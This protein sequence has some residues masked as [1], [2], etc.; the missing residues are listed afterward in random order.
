MKR[1][2]LFLVL[3]LG[4]LSAQQ[5]MAQSN[6]GLRAIGATAAFVSPENSDGTFGLGVFADLGQIAPHIGLE[7]H[8][9]FWSKSVDE[10]GASSSLRDVTVGARGKY[11]FEVQNPKIRPFAGAGLG[12]HFLHSEVSTTL[13]GFGP[14]SASASDAKLG[15][16]L[17]GGLATPINAK[18]DFRAEAW[19]GIVSDVSQFALRVGISH[20]LGM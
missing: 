9:E 12:L 17:G 14:M 10:F 2:A 18:N 19:Y 5:A 6:I 16:D 15:L 1:K 20:K 7:P 13:P 11:Y 3:A 8:I 4:L